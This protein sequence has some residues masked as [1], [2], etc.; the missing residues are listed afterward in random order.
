VTVTIPNEVLIPIIAFLAGGFLVYDMNK[1]LDVDG[2]GITW[3]LFIAVLWI[4]GI[5]CYPFYWVHGKLTG[6]KR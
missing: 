6:A 5:I 1:D 2:P 4:L 3:W